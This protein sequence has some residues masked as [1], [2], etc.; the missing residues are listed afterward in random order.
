MQRTGLI[1]S[2]SDEPSL[3][4]AGLSTFMQLCMTVCT[5]GGCLVSVLWD[6]IQKGPPVLRRQKSLQSMRLVITTR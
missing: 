5:P 4:I 2:E 1:L 6:S 3:V